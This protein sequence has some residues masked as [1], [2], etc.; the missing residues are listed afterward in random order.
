M[1]I[2]ISA[3]VLTMILDKSIIRANFETIG[4][5][6]PSYSLDSYNYYRSPNTDTSYDYSGYFTPVSHHTTSYYRE[7]TA[8]I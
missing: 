6:L 4:S 2:I 1:E 5:Y 3:K 8:G 7:L